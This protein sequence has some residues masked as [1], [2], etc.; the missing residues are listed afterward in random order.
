MS[1]SEE[2]KKKE[3]EDQYDEWDDDGHEQKLR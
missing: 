1:I 2:E 3:I